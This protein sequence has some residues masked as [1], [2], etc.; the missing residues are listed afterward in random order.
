MY[1]M[2]GD[3]ERGWDLYGC[4]LENGPGRKR[5]EELAA[6]RWDGSFLGGKPILL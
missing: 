3:Y 2:R 6:P 5:E 1:L 4:R